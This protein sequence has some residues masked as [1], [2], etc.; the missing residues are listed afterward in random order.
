MH[1]YFIFKLF[2]RYSRRV[3]WMKFA[4]SNNDPHIIVQYYLDTVKA[5]N[6]ISFEISYSIN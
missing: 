3:M 1:D 5:I 2:N 6:G 4:S